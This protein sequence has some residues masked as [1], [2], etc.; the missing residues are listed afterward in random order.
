MYI[1][2]RIML[3]QDGTQIAT[4]FRAELCRLY[5]LI[6]LMPLDAISAMS[7]MLG[8]LPFRVAIH[9]SFGDQSPER[10]DPVVHRR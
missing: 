2:M 4:V 5:V 9:E 3:C 7:L 6:A 10:V 8:F 1:K